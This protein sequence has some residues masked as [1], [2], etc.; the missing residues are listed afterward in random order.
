M[1]SLDEGK[2]RGYR[3]VGYADFRHQEG[4]GSVGD[5]FERYCAASAFFCRG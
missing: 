1:E 4:K 2:V 3:G 5:I